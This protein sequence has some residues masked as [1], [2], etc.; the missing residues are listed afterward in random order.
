M[1]KSRPKSRSLLSGLSLDLKRSLR[2]QALTPFPAVVA[3]I[4]NTVEAKEELIEEFT[5]DGRLLP[6]QPASPDS[7]EG[8]EDG[9][10]GAVQVTVQVQ[11]GEQDAVL[12]FESDMTEAST[13]TVLK[14]RIEKFSSGYDTLQP[15]SASTS[16]KK[17]KGKA[18]AKAN[19]PTNS[20]I[21]H[22]WD[23]STLVRRY[24][25]YSH[26]PLEIRKYFSQ[27]HLYF[28][29]YDQLPLLLDDTGWFSITP[30]PIAVHIAE[31][32][33]C[34]VIIDAFCGVGGNAVEFAKTCERVIAIDNDPTRLRLARH[35]AL[36]L[37][38]AD[39]IEFIL[40]DF[41]AFA[42]THAERIQRQGRPSQEIDV[43][44]LSPPWGGPEYLN[45]QSYPLSCL[46]PIPGKELF[47]V[48][49]ALTP[50]IAFYLPR[51]VQVNELSTL[52]PVLE[53]PESV[54]GRDR[55]REWVEVEEEW[56]GD[57]LKAVTAY[58]GGLV[59]SE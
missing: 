57:K 25:D 9:Q 8:D 13:S 26:V 2:S 38:V 56:V 6:T 39:R 32:C 17:R 11:D 44:F 46:L 31:R 12:I 47:D 45:T 49:A 24:S 29:L 36:H 41:P 18:K 15:W 19:A 48:S 34:D 58:F 23:C 10:D 54:N 3:P 27:R 40:A 20:Y 22:P 21:D 43:V 52:A 53:K 28:P 30:H 1:P 35:N 59:G 4:P 14:R 50:N 42:R 37:G 5:V 51:N 16:S 55:D 7:N 33:Q